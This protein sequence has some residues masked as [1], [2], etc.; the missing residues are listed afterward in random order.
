MDPTEPV[1]QFLSWRS[2]GFAIKAV[3]HDKK[4]ARPYYTAMRHAGFRIKDQPQLYMQK[5][6][7]FRYIEHKAK[8]GCLFYFAAEPF[9]YCVGNVR[10]TEKVDDAVQYEKI[11]DHARIDIFDA[12]VF[13]TVRLLIDTERS[14]AGAGWFDQPETP[15]DAR[16]APNHWR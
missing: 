9:E 11:S 1:K 3:G 4:F 5:S 16:G 7:G 2:R 8:V 13:A 12:A 15:K 6:E 10:A 14:S